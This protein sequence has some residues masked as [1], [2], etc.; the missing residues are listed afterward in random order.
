MTDRHHLLVH[1]ATFRRRRRPW[2]HQRGAGR[3]LPGR[4]V[5]PGRPAPQPL[6][7]HRRRCGARGA[8]PGHGRGRG[9]LRARPRGG[10]QEP[11]AH[12]LFPGTGRGDSSFVESVKV[13]SNRPVPTTVR[14]ALTVDADF[15]DQFELRP[16]T[17]PTSRPAWCAPV[18][19]LADGIEFTY[20]RAEWRSCTTITAEPAPDAVEE[21]GTGARRLVWTLDLEPHGTTELLLRVIA[22]PARRE[23]RRARALRPRRRAGST[24]RQR[25]RVHGGR[26]LPGRL[27]GAGCGLRPGPRRPRGAPGPG[28]RSG[29]RGTARAGGR[30]PLVPHPAR[31]RRA[32]LTSLFALPYRPQLAAATLPALAATQA[33]GAGG[34]RSPSPARSCTRY[35]TASWP[36]SARCRSAA[37]TA[38]STPPRC[39]SSCSARTSS[40]PGTRRWPAGWSR[41]PGP[42]SAG[43]STTAVS[44]RAAISS[45]APTRA[46]SPT[47]TGADSPARSAAPTA[48]G[49]P[50]R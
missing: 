20:R 33:T 14:L 3:Q 29:R 45:T 2:R 5:R 8:H 39:S 1:G 10:W 12:T 42:P 28:H 18:K 24:P 32:L 25:S 37:T 13:T 40:R 19:S 9:P 49:P 34:P 27:A 44:P 22:R 11:P 17:A 47:R 23:A 38:R 21:T 6:A 30:R 4:V 50:A 35:G 15:T 26:G 31:P 41:T 43:C 7:A 46:A 48:P 36:T 16:T